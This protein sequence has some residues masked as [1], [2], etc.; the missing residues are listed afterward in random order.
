VPSPKLED[1]LLEYTF[2]TEEYRA[3]RLLNPMQIALLQTKR[4]Q[5]LKL[6]ASEP[7]PEDISLNR[8][9]ITR[10]CEIDGKMA[11]IQEMFDDHQAAMHELSNPNK[12]NASV[13]EQIIDT[14]AER[15]SQLVNR[16]T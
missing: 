12:T 6:K 13:A 10:I 3:A 2:S 8:S 7:I 9:Y 15:A 5:L 14:V 4:A 11:Q 16:Q 1:N